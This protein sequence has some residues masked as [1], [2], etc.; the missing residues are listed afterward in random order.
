MSIIRERRK[1]AIL[2]THDIGEAITMADRIIVL[3]HR[4]AR[5]LTIHQVLLNSESRDPVTIREEPEYNR[6][7]KL[8]WQQ[9]DTRVAA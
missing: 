1:S 8:I 5:V 6:L 9:L 3:T 4:P 7:F 2:V